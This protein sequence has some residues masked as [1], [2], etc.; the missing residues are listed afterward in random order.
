MSNVFEYAAFYFGE[1][2]LRR[3]KEKYGEDYAANMAA[4]F[5]EVQIFPGEGSFQDCV[6]SAAKQLAELSGLEDVTIKRPGALYIAIY[7]KDKLMAHVDIDIYPEDK[8]MVMAN[9]DTVGNLHT[10]GWKGI[11]NLERA[12]A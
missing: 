6:E 9:G 11:R 4:T 7:E 12:A 8:A 3:V 5:H 10:Y 1:M 2:G